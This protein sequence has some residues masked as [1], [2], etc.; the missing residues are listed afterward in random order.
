MKNFLKMVFASTLGVFIA[1][2]I[3]F[4][5]SFVVLIGMVASTGGAAVYQVR[6]NTVLKISLDAVVSDRATSDPFDAL[7][8]GSSIEKVGLND[9]LSAIEKAKTNDKIS[10][11]YLEGGMMESGYANVQ[12]IRKALTDFKA[13]GKFVIAYADV[14][15]QSAYAIASVADS[16]YLNPQGMFDFRGLAKS[17][18]FNKQILEK[19]GIEMQ[20]Y[21]VGSYKSAVEP[22]TE[23]QMSAANREQVTAYLG[24]IWNTLLTGIAESRGIT[25]DQLNRYADE[26]LI[27]ADPQK[28]AEYKLIDDL[29]Y[30]DEVGKILK[31]KTNTKEKDDLKFASVS[32]LKSVPLERKS[33]AKETIA[34]LYAAGEIVEDA[35]PSLFSGGEN[36]ITAKEYVKELNKLRKDE[37]VKAVVFRVNSPGGSAFASEQIWHAVAELRAVKPVVVSMGNV[38]ASGGYYISVGATQIVAEPSTITG[39]LGIIGMLPNGAQWA[40]RLGAN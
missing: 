25:I 11:I 20:V 13:S 39:P 29:K 10:G 38:A 5:L 37:N 17:I 8:S 27:F 22:Y 3:L 2:G 26:C 15:A 4:F 31:T 9:I 7:F 14:Y 36:V 19:W 32:D 35:V 30:R 16:I 24:D 28:V 33:A 23:K 12:P 40:K 1:G 34:I 6:D 21:K 18:Q